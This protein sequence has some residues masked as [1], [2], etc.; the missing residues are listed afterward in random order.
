MALQ[1]YYNPENGCYG[2]TDSQGKILI[3]AVYDEAEPFSDG[4][5][6]VSRKELWGIINEQ[7]QVV[8]KPS[9]QMLFT[10]EG[11]IHA[12][13]KNA[14]VLLDRTGNVRLRIEDIQYLY[15][16][17]ESQVRVKKNNQWGLFALDG[18]QRIPFRYRSIGPCRNGRLA[19]YEDGC[20][21]WLDY[22]GNRRMAPQFH[23]VGWWDDHRWW[24]RDAAG[25]CLFDLDDRK[26]AGQQWEKITPPADGKRG[27]ARTPEGWIF[28][29]DQLSIVWRLPAGYEWAEDLQEGRAAVKK[30]GLW[31]YVNAEGNE[32]IPPGFTRASAFSEGLAAVQQKWN[33][34]YITPAGEVVIPFQF[35]EASPFQQG[36]AFVQDNY[37]GWY[38]DRNGQQLGEAHPLY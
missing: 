22:D 1:K 24:A 35:L 25:Y 38:I 12:W 20:W 28:L 21:G 3:P 16:P 5:A 27:A 2:F 9:Y 33:W 23:E 18:T 26:I 30:N 14:Q 32:V 13:E 36:S 34:G 15:Y 29:D 4:L 19:F 8:V 7:G 31:G 6:P 17:E 37:E 11:W 10:R